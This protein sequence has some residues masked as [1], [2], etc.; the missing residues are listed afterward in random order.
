MPLHA[1]PDPRP[2]TAREVEEMRNELAGHE[3]EYEDALAD[4]AGPWRTHAIRFWERWG[5]GMRRTLAEAEAELA[6][7]EAQVA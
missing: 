4:I 6:N 7:L 5:P 1:V 3:R 2:I